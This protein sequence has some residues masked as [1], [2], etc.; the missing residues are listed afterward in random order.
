MPVTETAVQDEIMTANIMNRVFIN[1]SNHPSSKW[2]KNQTEAA[3]SYGE[4]V[5]LPFPEVPA[6]ADENDVEELAL[7]YMDRIMEYRCEAVMVQGEFTLTYRLIKLLAEKQIISLAAC[8][9]RSVEEVINPD[10]STSR[11]INFQFVR[12]RRYT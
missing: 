5:D 1:L 11:K 3:R 12:F 9:E 4:I 10:G 7:E 2:D 8:S 6:Q